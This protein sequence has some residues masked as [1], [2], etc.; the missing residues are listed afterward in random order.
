VKTLARRP[1]P[2][3]RAAG[4]H[5]RQARDIGRRFTTG[6]RGLVCRTSPAPAAGLA[7]A[8]SPGRM[9]QPWLR[10][11]LEQAFGADL[12]AVRLHHD[13]LAALEARSQ[14]ADAFASGSHLYFA[15]G[16]YAPHSR[17]GRE[18]IAHEIAHVL[19][20]TAR[21]GADGRPRVVDRLGAGDLQRSW[22][23]PIASTETIP[24]VA[25]LLVAHRDALDPMAPE[26][27]TI[28]QLRQDY[29]AA[30]AG[31]G[32]AFLLSRS[33]FVLSDTP[34]PLLGAAPSSLN[35]S[36]ASA[37]YDILKAGGMYPAAAKMLHAR[38]DLRT[39]F[40]SADTYQQYMDTFASDFAVAKERFYHHWY[41][42]PWFGRGNP[43]F[44]LDRTQILLLGP[45][46]QPSAQTVA[47]GRFLPEAAVLELRDV[48]TEG[49]HPDELYYVTVRVAGE[50]EGYRGQLIE[51]AVKQTE[52]LRNFD[53]RRRVDVK[54]ALAAQVLQKVH[55]AE[56]ARTQAFSHIRADNRGAISREAALL[57][58]EDVLP[59]L[60]RLA[61]FARDFWAGVMPFETSLR[62]E[63]PIEG[64]TARARDVIGRI[65]QELPGYRPLLD[66]FLQSLLDRDAGGGLF[67]PADFE[68]RRDEAVRQLDRGLAGTVER[69]LADRLIDA[70]PSQRDRGAFSFDRAA[71]ERLLPAPTRIMVAWALGLAGNL[72]EIAL[73][74][75]RSLDDAMV[76]RQRAIDP[77]APAADLR[78]LTRIR[79]AARMVEVAR[80]AG[81]TTWLDWAGPIVSATEVVNG[82]PMDTDYLVLPSD[83]KR[84]PDAAITLMNVDLPAMPRGF[85]PMTTRDLVEFYLAENYAAMS[86]HIDE[87]L[88]TRSGV[89]D[90]ADVPVLNEAL[91]AARNEAHPR[92]DL[93][94]RARHIHPWRDLGGSPR[95]APR[96]SFVNLLRE[97]PLT[98]LKVQEE[99]QMVAPLTWAVGATEE[100][101][102]Q[103]A[104]LWTMPSPV[105]LMATVQAIPGVNVALLAGLVE[106][107]QTWPLDPDSGVGRLRDVIESGKA[108][109]PPAG[110]ETPV[111]PTTL[112]D[113]TP[114][115]LARL[116]L[117][118]WWA[119]WRAVIGGLS[120]ETRREVVARMRE[121]MRR[122][123]LP[124]ALVAER[125]AAEAQYRADE[126]RALVHERRR[127]VEVQLRPALQNFNRLSWEDYQIPGGSR[128]PKRLL[129]TETGA[130]LREFVLVMPDE[131]RKAHQSM[132]LLELS[133]VISAKLDALNEVKEFYV[134]GTLID[135]ALLW[136][137]DPTE[138]GGNADVRRSFT[139]AEEQDDDALFNARKA[140]LL[141]TLSHMAV[142]F[143][144]HFDRW[145]LIG[146]VGDGTIENPGR[147]YAVDE[148]HRPLSRGTVFANEGQ[149]YEIAE[150]KTA[151]VFHPGA[152]HFRSLPPSATAGS[153]LTI[154]PDEFAE[155]HRPHTL[156]LTVLIDGGPEPR[157][158]Y[159]DD[160]DATQL[161]SKLT[162]AAHMYAT[163]QQLGELAAAIEVF[164]E[165]LMTAAELFPGA[166]QALAAARIVASV[167]VLA[168]T[169]IPEMVADLVTH[170][171]VLL[172]AVGEKLRGVLSLDNLIEYLLFNNKSLN[173]LIKE[174]GRGPQTVRRSSSRRLRRLLNKLQTIARG[175]GR[176]VAKV[177]DAVQDKRQG[178]EHFVQGS[179]RVVRF[180]QIVADY[181]LLLASIADHLSQLDGTDGRQEAIQEF[182]SPED[183]A[184]KLDLMIESIGQ[185]ELPKEIL[186]L[187]ELVD[188]LIDV[189]GHRLGGK[190]KL[191]IRI[192]MELL[193]VVGARQE[194]VDAIVGA[195]EANG[196]TTANI[197][198]MW[199]RDIVPDIEKL[200]HAAQ[201]ELRN[202][203]NDAF[204]TL[205]IDLHLAQP[206]ARAHLE[207]SD[208]PDAPADQPAGG[209]AEA[210]PMLTE[211]VQAGIYRRAGGGMSMSRAAELLRSLP[212]EGGA[213]LPARVLE[214]AEERFG[215]GFGHVR[216]HTGGRAGHLMQEMGARALT[217]GSHV[218]L[219]GGL[220]DAQTPVL[221]HELS[222][223]VQQTGPQP[224]GSRPRPRRGRRGPGLR[225]DPRAEAEANTAAG[226]AMRGGARG[227]RLDARTEG[228]QPAL[229]DMLGQRFLRQ[230][231]DINLIQEEAADIE[232]TGPS[233][234]RRLIGRDV[235]RAVSGVAA[236]L[237]AKFHRGANALWAKRSSSFSG[238]IDEISAHLL[239]NHDVI[240]QAIEDIAIRASWEAERAKGN[241]PARM[242]LDIHD[243]T[244][245]LE[246]F[247]FGKTGILLNLDL[248]PRGHGR[249]AT[250]ANASAPYKKAEVTFVFLA[251]IHGNSR[252]WLD[253]LEYRSRLGQPKVLIPQGDRASWRTR[254]RAVLRDLG[255][256]SAVWVAGEYRLSAGVFEGADKLAEIERSAAIRGDLPPTALPSVGEYTNTASATL[257]PPYG[258]QRLHLGMY[259]QKQDPGQ[260]RGKERESHHLTQYLLA[261]YFH[262]GKTG[263]RETDSERMGFPLL[264]QDPTAYGPDL[265]RDSG[266]PGSFR[267]IKIAELED[268]RGGKMPTI[269]LA[270]GTHRRGNLHIS[271]KG[272]D[273]D[274]TSTASQAAVVNHMYKKRLPT[275]H[276]NLER[277][278]A[279]GRSAYRRWE[280]FKR[281]PRFN[282]NT[283]YQAMQATYAEIRHY[284]HRQLE[285]GLSGLERDYYNDVYL[286]GHPGSTTQLMTRGA[287]KDVAR[288]AEHHNRE[289]DGGTV[290]GM[291]HYG[292]KA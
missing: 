38:R 75:S 83:W 107:L 286:A 6:E 51:L 5:E 193:D 164:G 134:W 269:L 154:G 26:R 86:R 113:L 57:W 157:D 11:D 122:A 255:P 24:D 185:I 264:L 43:R 194:V 110:N 159:A 100:S 231:A 36:V 205:G 172:T 60:E 65:D 42:N 195:L 163:L 66:T 277:E 34:D 41:T 61:Q 283:I 98:R 22:A 127:V 59:A 250:F 188:T 209:S 79:L 222:H 29:I 210:Q 153:R 156:L 12:S 227:A 291:R 85:E 282:S 88:D 239:S 94:E 233:T 207:G 119:L 178:V 146:E 162:W 47:N 228:W 165:V 14:H 72:R 103:A 56:R 160:G 259:A 254:I 111:Q 121:A 68:R 137:G 10:C 104:V 37:L 112:D 199:Q 170:P 249:A 139:A 202:S 281:S 253:A 252:L 166:G 109:R 81:W 143:Q 197:F 275:E 125:R 19:Q 92:R 95:P 23:S 132:A 145:G 187:N 102:V 191:G 149:T 40:F 171:K 279:A 106:I 123:G 3:R 63:E 204:T 70:L 240:A 189:V 246:R 176:A 118:A 17:R 234:G 142:E 20:Q 64:L 80:I 265:Q 48:D 101:G 169:D 232:Q 243:F 77:A 52:S 129:A 27:R 35:T 148:R 247:I 7:V 147:A 272:D 226:A 256:S 216:L 30:G 138:G 71:A 212:D 155:G 208:F 179:P 218:V 1:G 271:P 124:D 44:I 130:L 206:A 97:H 115:L 244:R 173:G 141:A 116:T 46:A 136:A 192:L 285:S 190:Y 230:V 276:R 87:L 62:S 158:I 248:D 108:F 215:Q 58:Y 180:I 245:R 211:A 91:A 223:V 76:A 261:E 262:N 221:Y 21:A 128:V 183:F 217:S 15:D 78:A 167:A 133:D 168:S 55:E 140:R 33:T 278:V 174:R 268:G 120:A 251:A 151:F 84:D 4:S 184:G 273:F 177:Q 105:A 241:K 50:V 126:R 270:R 257:T 152:T 229:I 213:P 96:Q 237:R 219:D 274:D 69:P 31:G 74:Y 186:P 235:R 13:P 260:Q 203:L 198:P 67:S 54:A 32:A 280:D 181:Y 220:N 182:G 224:R 201:S 267:D 200:L 117:D 90:V 89:Y 28:E 39:R 82:T 266:Q 99:E 161:L 292:W 214:Q 2:T 144:R 73:D 258:N 289:G 238:K 9:L 284:M 242:A 8:G 25:D 93:I 175:A 225:F 135:E 236:N 45:S 131:D 196:V 114:A 49:F 263:T 288:K 287:M 16:A 18:L 150:V 53:R 290:K